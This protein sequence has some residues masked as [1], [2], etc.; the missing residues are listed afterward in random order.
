MD[1][2]K[3]KQQECSND[4]QSIF[5]YFIPMVGVYAAYGLS[6]Y[7]TTLVT[8]PYL[9]YSNEVDM[10]VALLTRDQIKYMRGSLLKLEHVTNLYYHF[11]MRLVIGDSGYEK[12]LKRTFP[13][14]VCNDGLK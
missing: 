11:H 4:G 13:L 1:K 3:I 7:Y 8:N 14:F 9:S 2:D 5:L 6:A 12:W 10:P